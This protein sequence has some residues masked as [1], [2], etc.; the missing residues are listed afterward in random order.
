MRPVATLVASLGARGFG[1]GADVGSLKAIDLFYYFI[2]E[3][4]GP[5]ATLIRTFPSAC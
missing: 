2:N 3:Q 4:V 5:L 1:R